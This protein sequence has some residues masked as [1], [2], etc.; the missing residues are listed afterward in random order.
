MLEKKGRTTFTAEGENLSQTKANES[1]HLLNHLLNA[2][3]VGLAL[4][5]RQ[6]E[7][8]QIGEMS[9]TL[10]K[11]ESNFRN[12]QQRAEH[13]EAEQPRVARSTKRRALVV[14]DDCNECEL[15][16]GFLRLAGLD[17]HTAGDGTAALDYLNVTG[18]PDFVVMDM[19]L[20]AARRPDSGSRHPRQSGFR[21]PTHL[22]RL[23]RYPIEQFHLDDGPS[24]IDHWFRKPINLDML[25]RQLDYDPEPNSNKA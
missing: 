17:V 6:I 3:T 21:R 5:R 16:A 12:V 18:K 1:I 19:V 14:E 13:L 4:L 24:G 9:S 2:N 25:L 7:L 10:D 8:G 22:W 15:L 11:I 20:P 23:R